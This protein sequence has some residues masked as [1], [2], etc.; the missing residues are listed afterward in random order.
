MSVLGNCV[1]RSPY[2]TPPPL[3]VSASDFTLIGLLST[4]RLAVEI[5]LLPKVALT[6]AVPGASPAKMPPVSL[7]TEGAWLLRLLCAVTVR[8][9]PVLS[10][11]VTCGCTRW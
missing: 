3:S 2:S 6:T 4:V 10:V 8:V 1:P 9:S 5:A 7:T 11:A